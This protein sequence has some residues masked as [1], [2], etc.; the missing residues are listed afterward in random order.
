MCKA[1]KT[2]KL[3]VS[4]LSDLFFYLK[5]PKEEVFGLQRKARVT[6]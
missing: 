5:I 2:L 3:A 4:S 1:R 6:K